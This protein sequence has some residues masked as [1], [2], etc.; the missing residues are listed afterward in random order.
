MRALIRDREALGN[1]QERSQEPCRAEHVLAV[2]Q[3]PLNVWNLEVCLGRERR[4]LDVNLHWHGQIV[5]GAVERENAGNL[6]V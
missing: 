5:R 6:N 1:P 4:S 2:F 3:A